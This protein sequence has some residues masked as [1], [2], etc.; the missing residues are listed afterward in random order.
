MVL[1]SL[2]REVQH[3][4]WDQLLAME[5][6][7]EINLSVQKEISKKNSSSALCGAKNGYKCNVWDTTSQDESDRS[8]IIKKVKLCLNL[9]ICFVVDCSATAP[10]LTSVSFC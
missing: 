5:K 3:Y 8:A 4:L 7:I 9:S 10:S 1:F 6:A 2:S